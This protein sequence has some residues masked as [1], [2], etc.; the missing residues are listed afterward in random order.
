[1]TRVLLDG[2]Y[3]SGRIQ[4][5]IAGYTRTL[6]ALLRANGAEVALLLDSSTGAAG[7][8]PARVRRL[9]RA[10]QIAWASRLG[11]V[12]RRRIQPASVSPKLPEHDA[13]YKAEDFFE[14][15]RLGFALSGRITDIDAAEAAG[16]A[17][18]SSPIPVQARGMA[19][20]YT[21]HDL[22][23]LTFPH[24]TVDRDGRAAR[25]HAAIAARADHIITV[26]EASREDICRVLSVAPDRVSVTYQPVPP[27]CPLAREDAERLVR[28][29]Y[30]LLPGEFILFCGA[31][32]PKKNLS[33]LIEAHASVETG[34]PLILVGPEGWM[35]DDATR[36][37]AQRGRTDGRLRYL[38]FLP[39]A[40]MTALMQ[41]ACFFAFPSISEGFG[42]PVLEAMSLGAPVLTSRAGALREISGSAAMLIDPL[43]IDA[44]AAAIRTLAEDAAMRAELSRLGP[45]RAAAFSFERCAGLLKR[46]YARAGITL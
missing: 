43:D 5:G 40:D 4:S 8:A 26:S 16:V 36:L 10:G 15:A 29:R 12:P 11:R 30:G 18:W 31:I 1:M 14:Y 27:L 6:A 7:F 9:L 19:N 44:M 38:G 25:L 17:H 42:L 24:L 22:I 3:L 23:P 32:E 20:L 2:S 46:A 33:R 21:I 37:I 39:R 28:D 45:A 41:T 34:I 35:Q 13:L